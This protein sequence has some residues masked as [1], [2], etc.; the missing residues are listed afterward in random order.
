ML[1][2]AARKEASND[3]IL[4][5]PEHTKLRRCARRQYTGHQ[6]RYLAALPTRPAN[7]Y[8]AELAWV[9]VEVGRVVAER[10]TRA[11]SRAL[12][13]GAEG[14]DLGGLSGRHSDAVLV[15][16]VVRPV[17]EGGESKGRRGGGG[18]GEVVPRRPC[19]RSLHYGVYGAGG[20]ERGVDEHLDGRCRLGEGERA[21]QVD[22]RGGVEAGEVLSPHAGGCACLATLSLCRREPVTVPMESSR[23]E[24]EE[25]EGEERREARGAAAG[26]GEREEGVE[27]EDG[28]WGPASR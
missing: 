4:V 14:S 17:A 13:L 7:A 26:L 20:G 16:P 8:G 23:V 25:R 28:D 10:V 9:R 22:A 5:G 3:P 27:S 19:G 15:S 18:N 11:V 12:E 21:R 2:R 1:P 6:D 24:R